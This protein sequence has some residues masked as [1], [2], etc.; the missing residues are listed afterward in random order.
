MEQH[1]MPSTIDPTKTTTPPPSGAPNNRATPARQSLAGG[2][3]LFAGVVLITVGAFQFFQGLAAVLKGDFYVIAPEN[4]YEFSVGGWG[5]VHLLL[6][7]GLAVTGYFIL[8]GRTWAKVLGIAVAAVS[9]VSN[10]LFIPYYTL[11]AVVIIALDV[12]VIW[13]LTTYRAQEN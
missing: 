8:A 7:I 4:I 6:G 13:A 2:L 10:F 11:W 12:A 3:T 5:W 1:T 9:A